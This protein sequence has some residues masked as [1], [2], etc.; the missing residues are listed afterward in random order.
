MKDPLTSIKELC[1]LGASPST[2][3]LFRATSYCKLISAENSIRVSKP[4]HRCV[5][6]LLNSTPGPLVD[7]YD[8]IP[9]VVDT[10]FLLAQDALIGSDL[11]KID[12]FLPAIWLNHGG[13]A[14]VVTLAKVLGSLYN[15][16][17]SLLVTTDDQFVR[18]GFH[19]ESF[20]V[21]DGGIKL[22]VT[23]YD[24]VN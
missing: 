6:D 15:D 17:C 2:D 9:I 3:A 21:S 18:I 4:D 22:T 14:R 8:V 24:P 19:D 5:I 23:I 10:I 12:M 20:V 11:K 13:H 16:N 7:Y 1:V